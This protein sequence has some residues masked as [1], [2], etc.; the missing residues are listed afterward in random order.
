[1]VVVLCRLGKS[2]LASMLLA[3][4][5]P[6]FGVGHD[7]DGKTRGLWCAFQEHDAFVLCVVDCE[8]LADATKAIRVGTLLSVVLLVLSSV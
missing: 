1:M 5:E 2:T 3:V 8:G 7:M 6:V 4:R